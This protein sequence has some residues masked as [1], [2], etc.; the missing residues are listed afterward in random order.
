MLG[1]DR[2]KD[3]NVLDAAYNDAA[4]ITAAFNRN[5]L[6]R[7]NREHDADFDLA[8]FAHRAF[9]NS[10]A[11]RVEMH[12]VSLAEQSVHVAGTAVHFGLGETIW[13]ESSYKYDEAGV[14]ELVSSAGFRIARRWTDPRGLFWVLV[15]E[16]ESAAPA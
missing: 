8:R 3:A 6:T 11:S 9:F 13:T 5:V 12:L 2:R 7:L 10:H 14:D 1:V 15:R 4:G 16:S